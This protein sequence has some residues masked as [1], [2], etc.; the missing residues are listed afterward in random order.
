MYK[1]F[2]EACFKQPKRSKLMMRVYRG[3]LPYY[4]YVCPISQRILNLKSVK[5][6]KLSKQKSKYIAVN[7]FWLVDFKFL[8]GFKFKIW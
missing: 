7:Y 8:T 4:K 6:F 1:G 5:N 2:L 3:S